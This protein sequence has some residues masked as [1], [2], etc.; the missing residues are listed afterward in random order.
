MFAEPWKI[1]ML[2]RLSAQQ[3]GRTITRFQTQKTASLIAYLAYY[4]HR[5]HPREELI[6]RFWPDVAPEAG[7]TSLRTALASLRRQLEPPGVSAGGVLIA[8]RAF[9]RLNPQAVRTD[10]NQFQQALQTAAR[11]TPE[12]Q[13]EP[14]TAA[15]ELYT[16][17]L[18][19]GFYDEWA[20]SERRRLAE[21]YL[22]AL[23]QLTKLLAQAKELQ[24]A[25]EMARRAVSADPLREESHR[26]L[27][28]LYIA[29]GRPAAALQ[30]YEEME[31]LLQEKLG[32]APSAATRALAQELQ[33][34][35]PRYPDSREDTGAPREARPAEFQDLDDTTLPAPQAPAIPRL[36]LQF[37]RFFGREVESAR[38]LELLQPGDPAGRLLTLTGPGGAGKTRLAI[39]T[40]GRLQE[41]FGGA[42]WFVPL[43][44][45]TDAR[46]I[47]R[48]ILEAL[49]QPAVPDADPLEQ[50]LARLQEPPAL[51]VLDNFE[52]VVAE[53]AQILK[54]LLARAPALT[55]LVTSRQRLD[56][57]GEREITLAPLPAPSTDL[58]PE[59]LVQW[60]SVALFVDRAQA[61]RQ[62]FQVTRGNAAA[63]AALCQRLEGLPLAIELAAAWAQT[64][65]PAQMLE[66][67]SR[68][69]EI[70]VSRR[71]DMEER[72][73]TL[74][75]AIEWSYRMLS[76]Q[77]QTLFARLSVFRGGW[78]LEAAEAICEQESGAFFMETDLLQ[79]QERSLIGTEETRGV[80]RFRMLETLRQ[81]A[82]EQLPGA[83]RE[84]T[85]HRHAGYFLALAVE[86]GQGA[87][88]RESAAHMERLDAERE[89]LRVALEWCRTAPESIE[90]G[91]EAALALQTLWLTRGPI[92]EARACVE[93]LLARAGDTLPGAL[94]AQA[95]GATGTLAEMQGDRASARM[96]Y[97]QSLALYRTLDD[98]LGI[99]GQLNNLA[100]LADQ[101]GDY[102]QAQ[103][104]CEEALALLSATGDKA[105]IA[106]TLANLG[107]TMRHLGEFA[108]AH[109]Y[110]AES[111]A[112]Y[113]QI[114]DF[115]RVATVLHNLG[116]LA[117]DRGEDAQARRYLEE[118]VAIKREAGNKRGIAYSLGP[119]ADLAFKQEDYA[120]A[121]ALYSESLRALVEVQ[122]RIGALQCLQGLTETFLRT[123]QAERAVRLLSAVE[124]QYALSEMAWS[125]GQPA[126]LTGF[127]A[128]ARAALGAERFAEVYARAQALTLEQ[129]I[130][131]ALREDDV[132]SS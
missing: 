33:A 95:L 17:E 42:V 27:M 5:Q 129:A 28:R 71:K 108:R 88:G 55:C 43:A 56:I 14:L 74:R 70:L 92:N 83:D 75:A 2:G 106:R 81:F 117:L 45:L 113:R 1:E 40:A 4:L 10:V 76:P 19:P 69:F 12:E 109:D 31:W 86:S 99:A 78:T 60:P 118:S 47:P 23:R 49:Q 38:L 48:A 126:S 82:D 107:V 63:V 37:T 51:L 128:Q 115:R 34:S 46:Q 130:E 32:M 44:D 8:E 24:R 7:R 53:G 36:P 57:A 131:E 62:D 65:T 132:P 26:S 35:V 15:V 110:Y 102:R 94:C 120:L 125:L 124:T 87:S 13:S 121:R 104:L 103:A 96:G 68:R 11:L 112:V 61:H 84:E 41:R 58:P 114:E 90:R 30:Q 100:T 97:Q 79:L 67:L 93:G 119:L 9:V 59:Q 122:D 22:G 21:A 98:T 101:Q 89:N 80:M 25:L 18:L 50:V 91:L 29:L 123:G 20:L 116:I 54:T 16:G 85:A 66:R 52:Q 72:H 39:E 105:A 64:L 111:L 3:A 127:H 6:D 73:R 77:L